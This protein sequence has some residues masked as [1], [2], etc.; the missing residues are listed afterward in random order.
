MVHAMQ[1]L[2]DVWDCY[3]TSNCAPYFFQECKR[4]TLWLNDHHG[5]HR[6][7]TVWLLQGLKRTSTCPN[8]PIHSIGNNILICKNVSKNECNS[9]SVGIHD[10]GES[11]DPACPVLARRRLDD[12]VCRDHAGHAT[13]LLEPR[14]FSC[15]KGGTPTI[16]RLPNSP[17]RWVRCVLGVC[18][19]DPN[20]FSGVFFDV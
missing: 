1:G 4:K 3:V 12:H 20:A 11:M 15:L 10:S 17:L 13:F 9:A 8:S 19:W 5:S 7:S 16:P 6:S 14:A 2:E 18:F